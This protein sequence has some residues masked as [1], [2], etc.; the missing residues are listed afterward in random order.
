MKKLFS[1]SNLITLGILLL[2]AYLQLPRL[3]NNFKI[4]GQEL[5]QRQYTDLGSERAVLFPPSNSPAI[6]IFWASWCAPC[7]VEMQRFKASVESGK[8]PADKIFAINAFEDQAQIK[9][10]LRQ[11]SF[12]FVFIQSPE[13][14]QELGVLK[15]PTTLR[16]ENG[17]I[18]S[19][20]TGMSF[21]G[22]WQAESL[23]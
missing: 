22:I 21:I 12:P 7:K 18:S 17:T 2:V 1:I 19:M 10:F 15:T 23:F 6:A 8:I 20:G 5:I 9:H 11:H 3:L 14:A 16:L 4:Q 13:L